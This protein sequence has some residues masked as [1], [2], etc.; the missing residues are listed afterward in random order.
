MPETN[1]QAKNP[2]QIA[3]R[4][5]ELGEFKNDFNRII[6]FTSYCICSILKKG[7]SSGLNG[8]ASHASRTYRILPLWKPI[9]ESLWEQHLFLFFLQMQQQQKEIIVSRSY[10]DNPSYPTY[11]H[12]RRKDGVETQQ[13]FLEVYDGS[14]KQT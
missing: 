10:S 6:I 4:A 7:H 12:F 8:S 13:I 3:N 11:F 9:N 14:A 5:A 1:K 2:S